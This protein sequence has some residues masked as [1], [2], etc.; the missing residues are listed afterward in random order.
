MTKN[1]FQELAKTKSNYELMI[2]FNI[3]RYVVSFWRGLYTKKPATDIFPYPLCPK[4]GRRKL[5]KMII[6]A[7][8][9]D[10]ENPRDYAK[11]LRKEFKKKFG[12]WPEKAK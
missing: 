1:E 11:K 8:L 7:S 2:M 12:M 4:D 6:Q 5:E 10:I 9:E 3:S